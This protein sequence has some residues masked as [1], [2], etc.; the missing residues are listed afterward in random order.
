MILPSFALITNN[1]N[2]LL[3]SYFE[4]VTF[5]F[6]ANMITMTIQGEL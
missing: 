1:D 2:F 3:M 4:H 5:L 6:D